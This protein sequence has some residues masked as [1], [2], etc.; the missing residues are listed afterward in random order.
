MFCKCFVVDK[1]SGSQ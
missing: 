1:Y